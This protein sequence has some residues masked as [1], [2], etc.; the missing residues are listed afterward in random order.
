MHGP[1]L[2]NSGV[3]VK[4][5]ENRP[6]I[7]VDV[8]APQHQKARSLRDSW[9]RGGAGIE[10]ERGNE[11][12]VDDA[13]PRV[14][15]GL[16]R[17]NPRQRNFLQNLT[18]GLL[19]PPATQAIAQNHSANDRR[20]GGNA[21]DRPAPAPVGSLMAARRD[22]R[23]PESRHDL[24]PMNIACQCCGALHWIQERI[25]PSEFSPKFGMCCNSG[26]VQLDRLH[27]PP[28]PLLRL[29]MG[30]DAQAQKFGSHITQYNA[31]LAFTSLG[32]SDD[33]SVNRYGPNAW[34]F[35]ILGNSH[36]LSGALTAPDGVA[37]SCAQLYMYDP[38]V[39]LQQQMNRN[40]NLRA[41]TMQSLQLMLARSHPYVAMYKQAFEVLEELGDVEDA[42]VRLRALPGTDHRRYNLPTAEEVAVIL[43]GDGSAGDGRDII[44]H[45]R[46]PD[47][48]PMLRI[49][50]VHPA[51]S[52]LYY[53]LLFP[54][55]E[56]GWHA[57]L[58]LNEPEK[59][60][61]GKT[62]G[63]LDTTLSVFSRETANSPL[64]SIRVV[65]CSNIWSMLSP[66]NQKKIRASVYNGLE[67]AISSRDDDVD[68]N[69][70]GR[71]YILPSSYIGGP[72]HMQQRYQDAMA[73]ARYYRKV[74]LFI[75]VTANPQWAEIIR[76]LF[77]GQTSYDRPD[78]VACIF[79]L[80]KKS[81]IAEIYKD[82]IF[83]KCAAFVYT[84]EFQKRGP[85][86]RASR[87]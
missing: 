60:A 51:Y 61:R 12:D 23:E 1:W 24:G 45:N 72:R 14:D 32:V 77:P 33:K 56:H 30:A 47:N 39:A 86:R 68:L 83:G 2:R 18:N 75:T 28:Q 31:A 52:P 9:G 10:R 37:P 73:I 66:R 43:P 20:G 46:M 80:K 63:C 34:V 38:M 16:S 11:M 17:E 42:E 4:E 57:H 27:E 13:P 21:P 54:R 87:H 58:S 40:S 22:Y 8:P 15:E 74:D 70:L 41:D 26:K 79:Q 55:G 62:P 50:D 53:V 67:D 3:Y 44:L 49:S 29:L 5:E 82:G 81:I 36:H 69:E 71:R 84:I 78:L 25:S 85:G 64:S 6:R 35:R 59:E 19:S 48:A 65:F 76:A 7:D